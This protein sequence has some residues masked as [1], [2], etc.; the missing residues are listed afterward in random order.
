MN[1][2]NSAICNQ[3]QSLF[4]DK[5]CFSKNCE[6]Q[7]VERGEH[8]DP[9]EPTDCTHWGLGFL[10]SLT[11]VVDEDAASEEVTEPLTTSSDEDVGEVKPVYVVSCTDIH[12][13]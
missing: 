2:A 6:N 10:N 5:G 11:E 7:G 8:V 13:I 9:R 1:L 3:V 4:F 12:Y